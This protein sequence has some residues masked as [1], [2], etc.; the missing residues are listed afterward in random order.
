LN[1]EIVGFVSGFWDYDE[2]TGEK[3][4]YGINFYVKPELRKTDIGKKLHLQ[5]ID[6]GKKLDVKRV[7]RNVTKQHAPVLLNK[8]QEL[9]HYVI[10]E[11]I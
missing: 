11:R 10:E 2:L 5:Y 6:T 9:T 1:G 7:I 8:K 3:V 4:I